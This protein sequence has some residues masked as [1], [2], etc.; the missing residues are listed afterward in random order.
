MRFKW[1][2][3]AL[4]PVS[5]FVWGRD[6]TSH[7]LEQESDVTG[8]RVRLEAPCYLNR[9]C[10]QQPSYNKTNTCNYCNNKDDKIMI[11]MMKMK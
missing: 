9:L 8:G 4:L 2:S 6:E 7:R 1:T 11:V 5:V 10:T 3:V